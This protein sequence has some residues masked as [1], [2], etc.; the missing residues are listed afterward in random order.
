MFNDNNTIEAETKT[1]TTAEKIAKVKANISTMK[2]I[3][4]AEKEIATYTAK[5]ERARKRIDELAKSL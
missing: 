4:K 2:Q 3:E 5:I 1:E